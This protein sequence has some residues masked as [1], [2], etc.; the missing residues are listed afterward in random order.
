MPSLKDKTVLIIGR[1]SG[2]ARAIAVAVSEDGGQVIAAGRHPD[3]LA[4]AYRRRGCL[5]RAAM[6]GTVEEADDGLPQRECCPG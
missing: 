5:G 1:D 6:T 2:I 4:S 3:D